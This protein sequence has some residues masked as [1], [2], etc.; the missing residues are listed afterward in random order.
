MH[1]FTR[2]FFT[3]LITITSIFSLNACGT[4]PSLGSKV[5]ERE[6][7]EACIVSINDF[8]AT[9]AALDSAGRVRALKADG[10]PA[11]LVQATWS[12]TNGALVMRDPVNTVTLKFF[13][14]NGAPATAVEFSSFRLVMDMGG[15]GHTTEE[16][17]ERRP[18]IAV[19][20]NVVT[21]KYINFVMGTRQADKWFFYKFNANVDGVSGTV[22]RFNIPYKVQ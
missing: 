1:I 15:H 21:I 13:R 7:F 5:F 6:D 22:A 9:G 4:E 12:L 19:N 8:A 16:C 20:G 2:P 14:P 10:Q 18:E 17:P 3:S 11:F